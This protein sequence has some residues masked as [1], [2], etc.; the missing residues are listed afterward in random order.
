MPY[1]DFSSVCVMQS[2]SDLSNLTRKVWTFGIRR[3]N[4]LMLWFLMNKPKCISKFRFLRQNSMLCFVVN[5]LRKR[6]GKTYEFSDIFA[7]QV[8]E[9]VEKP[10]QQESIVLD[11]LVVFRDFSR[12]NKPELSIDGTHLLQTSSSHCWWCYLSPSLSITPF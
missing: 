11:E 5:K 10:I 9:D 7:M 2:V 3:N 6:K 4:K 8:L 12:S 1:T